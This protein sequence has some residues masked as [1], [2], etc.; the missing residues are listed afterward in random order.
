MERDS[1]ERLFPVFVK[2]ASK[3]CTVVGGGE[4]AARKV[5]ALLDCE[6]RVRVIAPRLCAT[7]S[8]LVASGEV[9][10]LARSYEPG[11]LDGSTLAFGAT[12]DSRV[13]QAVYREA[14]GLGILVNVV[15]QPELCSFY[16]PSTIT[17]GPIQVA[18][19]TGGASPALARRLRELLEEV[20]TPEYGQLASLLGSLREEVKASCPSGDER[21]ARWRSVLE[22]EVL[23]LLKKGKQK[24]AESTARRIIGLPSKEAHTGIKVRIGT[25]GSA[26]ALAQAGVVGESLRQAGISVELITIRTTG[27]RPT[28]LGAESPIGMFVREIEQALVH[29]EVD[30]AV[31]S[32]KDLPTGPRP[33]LVIAAVP[34][35]EDPG[36]ALITRTG[37]SLDELPTGSRVATASPR[38]VAQLRA[39]R[40]DLVFVPVKGNVD[41]RLRKLERGDFDA[42][43]LACAGLARLG[44]SEEITERLS[45]DICLPA[46]GQ[47]A[48]SLQVRE[49][50]SALRQLLEQFD[51]A[52]SRLAV[53][54][55]R[56]FL[57][58]LGGGCSVAAGALGLVTGDRLVLR[59][60]LETEEGR[61]VRD[62]IDGPADSAAELGTELANRVLAAKPSRIAMD[63]P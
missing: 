41:T 39:H 42:V 36:D 8:T 44:R 24:E 37:Q 50:D 23:S 21:E 26:L 28:A 11:D 9:E 59:G 60:V 58:T 14:E 35:R 25:R 33:G 45:Y 52:P 27:D 48:L 31:H 49:E 12:D 53:E 32:L 10:H 13:N 2:L 56:A 17:R 16:V 19:S 5:R 47:G 30:L 20:I 38:R 40:P 34:P 6:A 1:T 7:L 55:E 15:D 63:Q 62:Q 22:G 43:V 18:I 46:P 54:A 4:V 3:L 51:H 57:A 29:S 61:L